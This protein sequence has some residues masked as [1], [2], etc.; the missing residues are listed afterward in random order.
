MD[1]ADYKIKAEGVTYTDD[2]FT[3]INAEKG[4][5]YN[6]KACIGEG[7]VKDGKASVVRPK[8]P[9]VDDL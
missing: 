3:P 4:K 9:S 7:L 2:G 1:R 8:K 5:T 6:M